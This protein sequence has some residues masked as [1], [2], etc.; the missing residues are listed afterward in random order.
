MSSTIVFT[1]SFSL[2]STTCFYGYNLD[3][4]H[5]RACSSVG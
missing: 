5:K 3:V 1:N 2:Y 4:F